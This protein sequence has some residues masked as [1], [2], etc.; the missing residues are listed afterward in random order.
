[1]SEHIWNL[2]KIYEEQQL[3]KVVPVENTS[4]EEVIEKIED[5]TDNEDVGEKTEGDLNV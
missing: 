2:R 5:E 4:D 1:M 3:N